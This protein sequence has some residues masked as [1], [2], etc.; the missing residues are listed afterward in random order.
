MCGYFKLISRINQ[1]M[2]QRATSTP[3]LNHAVRLRG[4]RPPFLRIFFFFVYSFISRRDAL[5]ILDESQKAGLTANN[6]LALPAYLQQ[7]T[8]LYICLNLRTRVY[9]CVAETHAYT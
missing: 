4:A 5:S 7:S 1:A 6:L 2:E 8:L 9:T 3:M